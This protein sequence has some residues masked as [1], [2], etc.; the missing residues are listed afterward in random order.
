MET[1][2]IQGII[3]SKNLYSEN[4]EMLNI[5]TKE[6]LIYIYAK[7]VRK[8]ESKNRVNVLLGSIVEFEIFNNY[9]TPNSFLLKKA[10]SIQD[11]PDVNK[12]NATKIET[13]IKI[14]KKIYNSHQGVYDNY[15]LLLSEF[16]G[17]DFFWIQSYLLAQILESAGEGLSFVGCV[18]CSSNQR[19]FSFDV[20]EGG[21]LCEKHG[22]FKTPISLLKSFYF[23]GK[24]L[25]QYIKFTSAEDNKKIFK[26]LSVLLF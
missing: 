6:E 18:H 12:Q 2:K 5:L 19:L 11:L 21:M 3:I 16:E 15:V 1:T 10:V 9:S 13:L 4:D 8:I 26:I 20:S 22:K 23:L 14:M 7:G 25:D 24:P 17:V